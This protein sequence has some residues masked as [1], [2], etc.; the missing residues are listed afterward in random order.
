MNFGDLEI[1]CTPC[2]ACGCG[3]VFTA[4]APP[5]AREMPLYRVCCRC[6]RERDELEFYEL[7]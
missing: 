7:F 4:L 6:R 3:D 5:G 2:P 1:T